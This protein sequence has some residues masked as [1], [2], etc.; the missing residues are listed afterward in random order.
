MVALT[1]PPRSWSASA[2][3]PWGMLLVALL[4][5][6]WFFVDFRRNSAGFARHLESD[7]APAV[8]ANVP[9][10]DQ[11]GA[12]L[13]ADAFAGKALVLSFM[14]TSCPQVCPLQTRELA[15][16]LRALPEPVRSRVHFLSV[17]V[18]PEHDTPE[19]LKRFA[20]D[21]GV[22][23]ANWSLATAPPDATRELALTL[24]AIDPSAGSALPAA[25]GTSVYLF[26]RR[27]RLMQRYMGK[28]LDRQRLV[29]EIEQIARLDS[30]DARTAALQARPQT[31]TQTD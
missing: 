31:L 18:D 20:A 23:L 3:W 7:S 1:P 27:G 5:A 16:V 13:S 17:S 6:G 8:L 2:R 22:E 10:R 21:N 11:N 24:K 28:P 19:A 14:F 15:R 26:D 9:L 29:R 12:P 25:H 4:A 30:S